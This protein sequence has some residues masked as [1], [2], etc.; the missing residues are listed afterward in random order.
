M[1]KGDPVLSC[2]IAF[3]RMSLLFALIS[4]KKTKKSKMES[5][6]NNLSFSGSMSSGKSR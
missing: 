1:Q 6:G 2:F 4:K 5:N 3:L